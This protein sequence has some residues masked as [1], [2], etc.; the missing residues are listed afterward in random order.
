MYHVDR[1]DEFDVTHFGFFLN[2]SLAPVLRFRRSFVS[3]CNVLR[4]I[5]LHGLSA[6]KKSLRFFWGLILWMLSIG[7]ARHPGPCNPFDASGCSIEF[8]N[9]GG[10]LSGGDLAL[11]SKASFLAVA[12][13]RLVPARA[14]SCQDVTPGVH[15]G[16]GVISLHGVS[17]SPPTLFDPSFKEFFRMGR[18]M[19]VVL[20]LGNGGIAHLF[21]I[22]GYQGAESDP[23][24]LTLTDN[25]LTALLAEAQV[26]YAGQ[27]VILVGDLNADPTVIP[28]LAKGVM[29]GHWID[30]EQAFAIGRGV[31][32]SRPCQFQLDEDKAYAGI[33][34]WLVLLLWPPP[35]HVVFCQIDGSFRTL[36]STL[37]SLSLHGM[38]LL[39]GLGFILPSGQ[40]VGLIV[41][42][43]PDVR[44]L[45]RFR[46]FGMFTFVKSVSFLVRFGSNS[47][48]LVTP[49]M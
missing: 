31:A 22:Y 42:T 41:L 43:A 34:L 18:A 1:S 15:A 35:L 12:E 16:V 49:P 25:L 26:C 23:E 30:V 13:H 44:R 36:L 27:P 8:L 4:G 11:E 14:P 5:R 6:F 17:L 21:V 28:S 3:V 19:R 10:W 45:R 9:V 2:S 39:I 33:P 32:P 46:I 37:S 38:P 47:S 40:P 29:N 7:R 20:P 48:L 24:K